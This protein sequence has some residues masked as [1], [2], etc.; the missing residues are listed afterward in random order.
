MKVK[1][2]YIKDFRQFKEF[3]LDLSYPKGHEK[4]G[5]PLDKVCFIGQSGT[6]KTTLL[7]FINCLSNPQKIRALK[8]S[9][10]IK[11]I[12]FHVFFFTSNLNYYT[13]FFDNNHNDS[14][15]LTNIEELLNENESKLSLKEFTENG[16]PRTSG[17][18]SLE[19]IRYSEKF[20]T[21]YLPANLHYEFK[22]ESSENI[23]LNKIDFDF[24]EE[25][26][27]TTWN[28]ILGKV[29]KFQEDELKLRQDISKV[30]ESGNFKELEK[31][32]EKLSQWKQ[33]Y[34]NPIRDI[35]QNCID[36]LI[37]PFGLKVKEDLDI[38]KKED[39]GF[40]KI[41]DFYNN[42][43][44]F[45]LWST[46]TK[47]IILSAMA[48]YLIKPENSI[49]LFD[50]PERSLYP[51]LQR[52]IIKHYEGLTKNS[53]LFFATHSPIIASNFE[54]WEIVELKFDDKF[55]VYREK[56]YEGEND[57]DNYFIDPRFLNFDLILKEVFD[58]KFTNGDMRYEALSE[59]GMLKNQL[60]TFKKENKLQTPAAKEVYKKFKL[61]SKKLVANP[62]QHA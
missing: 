33:E 16:F 3:T 1:E 51:D 6:G 34:S 45:S 8:I 48:L 26:I 47:Q 58:M 38:R 43:V 15:W 61:L 54:P 37:K 14:T 56:Y 25:N 39:I 28:L 2:I 24:T 11:N 62:E 44:P 5:Q 55:H 35:A 50:E 10:I 29:T 7:N 32:L 59:Y 36:P 41:E 9:S 22:E 52:V 27:Y 19:T 46:G 60:E 21:V 18:K 4:E 13:S 23:S 57:I 42:E 20:K 53:Q 49:I 17:Q 31:Q 30:A 12:S 40:I